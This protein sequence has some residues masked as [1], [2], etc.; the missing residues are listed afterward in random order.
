M[1]TSNLA[2]VEAS[3]VR[4]RD[5]L[6]VRLDHLNSIL[7]TMQA[8]RV[9]PRAVEDG[10]IPPPTPDQ[11]KG[12]DV[13]PAFE[14]Y[15]KARRGLKI[16]LKTIERHLLLAGA[17]LKTPNSKNKPI[18]N[19]KITIRNRPRL[20][21]FDEDLKEPDEAKRNWTVWLAETS[22]IPPKRRNRQIRKG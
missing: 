9:V 1:A 21:E 4:E 6:Q 15:M 17:R 5:A 3:I 14:A 2:D 7:A 11:Y 12:M 19:L 18:Q 8:M 22:D 20:V 16:D 10:Q 13:S